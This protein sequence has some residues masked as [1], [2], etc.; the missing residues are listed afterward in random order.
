MDIK[1]KEVLQWLHEVYGEEQIPVYEKNER[2]INILH[3]L[4]KAS[5]RSEDNA[6]VLAADYTKKAAEYSAEAM[7][8]RNWLD[9]LKFKP[10]DLSEE[11]Q[12]SLAALANTAQVLD[13]QTPT[14]TNIVLALN[15]LEMD[16]MKVVNELEQEKGRKACLLEMS[17]QLS[18]KLEEIKRISQQAEATW[19]LQQEEL[20]RD[21]KRQQFSREKSNNYAADITHYE[22]KLRQVGLSKEITHS[23]LCAKWADLQALEK[24]VKELEQQLQNYTLPP[25]MALAEVKVQEARLELAS[26]MDGLAIT[27][28]SSMS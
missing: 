6:K 3:N 28:K 2:S 10:N 25:D 16:H 22:A 26:I 9:A 21:A 13:V 27:C 17:Q 8:K 20:S 15:Q 19:M 14:S 23:H 5:K 18:R 4:M 7:Q 24:Q 12:K 11:S 1:H